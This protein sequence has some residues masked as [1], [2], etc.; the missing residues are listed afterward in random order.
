MPP[1]LEAIGYEEAE[2]VRLTQDFLQ[3]RERFLH[4]LL[5]D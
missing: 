5:A 4:E 1:G 3:A 2:P